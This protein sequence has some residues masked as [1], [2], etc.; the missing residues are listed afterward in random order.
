MSDSLDQQIRDQL[1]RYLVGEQS[2]ADF[3]RWFM[4]ATWNVHRRGDQDLEALVGEVG[5]AMAEHQAGDLTEEQLRERLALVAKADRLQ[6]GPP[7]RVQTG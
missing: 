3:N 5:L 6:P 2:L 1:V 4:P 7:G